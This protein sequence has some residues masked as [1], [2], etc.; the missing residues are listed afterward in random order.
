M[1]F[2]WEA[3]EKR[4]WTMEKKQKRYIFYHTVFWFV[5]PFLVCLIFGAFYRYQESWM[6]ITTIITGS[7][8]MG[9][10]LY[11]GAIYVL[12]K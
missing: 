8:G 12:R 6:E 3:V 1:R 4:D 5:I 11:G 2:L 10:G 7:L 9:V